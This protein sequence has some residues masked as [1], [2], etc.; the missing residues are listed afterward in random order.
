VFVNLWGQPHGH[1]LGYPA[2]YDL[3]RRL[4]RRTGI[5]FDPHWCRHTAATRMQGRG[6]A[7]DA[8]FREKREDRGP[9][10]QL[11]R[12][13]QRGGR[14]ASKAAMTCDAITRLHQ[15]KECCIHFCCIQRPA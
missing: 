8:T 6:V 13:S 7:S 10:L 9:A 5:G 1:P 12:P 15:P 11:L 4:R 3:V 2:V 14:A